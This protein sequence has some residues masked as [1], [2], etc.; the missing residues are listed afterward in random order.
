MKF[1]AFGFNAHFEAILLSWNFIGERSER[2][3][4]FFHFIIS[5]FAVFLWSHYQ[6]TT[7][8]QFHCSFDGWIEFQRFLC[9]AQATWV[10]FYWSCVAKAWIIL[11]E[12]R[13]KKNENEKLWLNW[14]LFIHS[15][16]WLLLNWLKQSEVQNK[17]ERNDKKVEFIGIY[18]IRLFADVFFLD[19]SLFGSLDSHFRTLAMPLSLLLL[20]NPFCLD[21]FACKL[22]I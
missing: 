9:G 10:S 5:R 15:V 22:C 12:K 1:I 11:K 17:R 2:F 20:V 8:V 19:R 3:S 21:K 7:G 18:V 14:F 16:D 6:D 13:E 4:N